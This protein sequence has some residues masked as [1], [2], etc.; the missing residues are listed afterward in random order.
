MIKSWMVIGAIAFLL[1]FVSST[2]L[3]KRGMGWFNRLRRPAWLTFESAI[4]LIWITIF[5]CGAWSAVLVWESAPQ[6]P[7]TW[8]LMMLYLLLEI[9]TL[10]Y[11]SVMQAVRRLRVG[12]VIGA[13][14][15][16]IALFLTLLISPI[17]QWATLLMLP[18]LLWSPIGTY[19][20]WEMA[21][22]NPADA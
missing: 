16:F 10:S 17:S 9:V 18:Y 15:F 19:T 7:K 14:G 20:T 3:S 5:I 4:P 12:I 22:L 11:S 21:K 6:Q 1:A 2:F 13:T 8:L